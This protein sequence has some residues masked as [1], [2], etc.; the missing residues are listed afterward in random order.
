M[1][2]LKRRLD[3]KFD[4]NLFNFNFHSTDH[5]QTYLVTFI[6]VLTMRYALY[7]AVLGDHRG[8]SRND[9]DK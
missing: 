1:V 7:S 4:N 5:F 8:G 3:L 2:L 6:A 9:D